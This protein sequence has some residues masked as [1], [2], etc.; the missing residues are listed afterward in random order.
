MTKAHQKQLSVLVIPD[1]GSR[2]LEFR[3]GYRVLWALAGG[4]VVLLVLVVVGG[5]FF[6]QA[7]HW[8]QVAWK[9]KLDNVRLRTEAERIDELSQMVTRMKQWDQQ[10]R[11]MLSANLDLPPAAYM[12]PLASRA[13]ASGTGTTVQVTTVA[14]RSGVHRLVALDARWVPSIWPVSR[15][16][17]WMLREIKPR[18]GVFENP[19]PGIEIA[20]QTGTPVRATADGRVIF[21]N[22]DDTLGQMVVIDHEGVY[23]TR[24]GYNASLLVLEGQEVYRG[25]HIALVGQADRN[26]G[27]CLHYGVIENGQARAPHLFL[28]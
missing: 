28:P 2:T 10:L 1:D 17:G 11:T 16:K 6:W 3:V 20:V 19:H 12:V 8:E 23:L 21:A 24:Y 7:R 5:T 26:R 14:D 22:W 27:P 13:V 4:L 9:L 18:V 25:Q 15:S